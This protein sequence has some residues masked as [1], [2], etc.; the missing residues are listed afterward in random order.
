MYIYICAIESALVNREFEEVD[1][2]LQH[3][4]K[5]VGFEEYLRYSYCYYT[6]LGP[7]G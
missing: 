2:A 3:E 4:L 1:T 5:V 7:E 6:T